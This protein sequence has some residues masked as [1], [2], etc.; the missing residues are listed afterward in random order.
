MK[1]DLRKVPA[2]Y[3]NLKQHE[4]K[5][6]KMQTLLGECGF[7]T[8][9]C[10]EGPYRPDNP[11]A[12]CAGAHYVGLS[13]IDPPFILFEDDCLLHNFKPEIEVPDDADAIY[14]GT[15]QWARYFSF[16]G[17]FVHYDI[18]DKDIVRVY[19]M[20]GGH[21]I[22]YLTQE[23]VRMCQR[24]SYHASQVIGYNQDPGFAEVQKYFNI[25]SVNDPFFK[26]SGYNNSV[27]ACKITDIG[28]HVSDAQRFFDN[29][30]YDLARLQGVSDLNG[31]PSTYHP[32]RIV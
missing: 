11:P 29:V 31:A 4:E 19:N 9:I 2:V 30:K 5:N 17:P 25:Y 20:L 12:G 23:Y 7:E 32:L 26:Q 1:I 15:S 24:I 18:V 6:E 21:S 14:L 28:I 8:I 22:L 10:V 13:K 16:S 27:T 3:M